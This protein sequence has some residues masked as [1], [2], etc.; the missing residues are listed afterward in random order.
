MA[1]SSVTWLA[2]C[3]LKKAIRGYEEGSCLG[4]GGE[5]LEAG[6]GRPLY[7][8]YSRGGGINI[9]ILLG[10]GFSSWAIERRARG[11][12]GV[13]GEGIL[14]AG[15]P[16]GD[17][18]WGGES[19]N[20]MPPLGARPSRL[21]IHLG[22]WSVSSPC[23][24]SHS[25]LCPTPLVP[26]VTPFPPTSNFTGSASVSLM[27]LEFFKEGDSQFLFFGTRPS[28]YSPPAFDSP[29]NLIFK[30]KRIYILKVIRGKLSEQIH[31]YKRWKK[32]KRPEEYHPQNTH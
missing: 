4:R 12:L 22:L 11:C 9:L 5:R 2:G 23:S 29:P 31:I 26:A 20:K 19:E 18:E 27:I 13:P 25:L 21:A 6:Q 7:A 17:G 10:S 1:D 16:E 14:W 30:L 8:N 28:S 15:G 24:A 32:F 3:P